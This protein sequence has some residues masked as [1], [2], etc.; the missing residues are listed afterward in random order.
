NDYANLP[1][2]SG[3]P[4]G[5]V[6]LIRELTLPILVDERVAAIIGVG[7]KPEHY[8][9]DD[10]E[11]MR[12]FNDLMMDVIE[13]K[14][15][16]DRVEH[17]AYHDALTRL[18]NRVLLA[19]RLQQAMAQARRD[20][21]R[22]A[23][24]YLD[25]DDFKPINDTYG[26]EQGDQ[27]LIEVAHRLKACVRAGDTVARLGGDEFVLLLGNLADIE[28]CEHAMDRLL[29]A[30]HVP[31]VVAGQPERLSASLG[32]TLYPDDDADP[33]TL[34]RHVDQ[35]MY[36]AKQ[37]GGRRYQWFDTDYDRRARDY[38]AVLQQVR[39]GLAAGEFCL[40]YQPKVDMRR[41]VVMGAEAL[42]RWQHPQDG[43]LSPA[44]F[45]PIV[46]TSELAGAV[47][48]WVL[49]E[50]L[51]QMTVW[52]AAG[53]HL[54]VSVNLSGRHLLQPGFITQLETLLA[55]YPN[56]PPPDLELEILETATLENMT[57]VAALITDC[58]TLGVHFALDDFGTGYSSLTYLKHLPVD[59]LKIDQSFVRDMLTDSDA[60]AIVQGIIGLSLAFRRGVIAEGVETVEQGRQLIDLGCDFAQGYGIARPMPPEQIPDW[61]I[62]WTPPSAWQ[63]AT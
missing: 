45:I 28:E 48:Y 44:R 20:Q 19:D 1:D 57:A 60:L 6:A 49:Q 36:T 42:I 53:L 25:L 43:L 18:P 37:A 52:A 5:H 23:V 58:R 54:P 10:V 29:T 51:R 7:N 59:A 56:V 34:L 13:R 40:Y 55:A 50:A 47:G 41:G 4:D 26:H 24:C 11:T 33:D 21:K 39:T 17:L 16:Q 46:D 3:L 14:R 15:S 22:L 62:G 61:I 30:L 31:F 12:Q 32:I 2:P 9:D 27:I 8:T 63:K 35:A 38:R